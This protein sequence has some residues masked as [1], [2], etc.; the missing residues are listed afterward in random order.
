MGK[1]WIRKDG[2]PSLIQTIIEVLKYITTG[3]LPPSCDK[4]KNFIMDPKIVSQSELIGDARLKFRAFNGR[5]V[6]AKRRT[7]LAVT[8]K[9]AKFES[10]E[11]TLKTKD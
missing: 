11:Q 1:K 2:I 5:P 9:G 8:T 7:L 4:G 6:L 3:A 10:I